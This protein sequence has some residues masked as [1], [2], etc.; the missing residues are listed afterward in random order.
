MQ[1]ENLFPKISFE[2]K[3]SSVLLQYCLKCSFRKLAESFVDIAYI[4]SLGIK[5][6][7]WLPTLCLFAHSPVARAS[8]Q[9]IC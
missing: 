7:T 9:P 2:K 8:R 1:R 4:F 6:K 3:K 5:I